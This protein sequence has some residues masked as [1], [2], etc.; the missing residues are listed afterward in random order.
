MN[1]PRNGQKGFTVL[2]L[3][4]TLV[5]SALLL[6]IAIPGFQN[7]IHS[8]MLSAGANT[9]SASLNLARA[10]AVMSRRNVRMCPS[11]NGTS[12]VNDGSW[13]GGWILF[14][15]DNGNGLP[16]T[17]ELLQARGAWDSRISL[18]TPA[19]FT[20]YI[21]FSPTGI[22]LGNAGSS[23]QFTLCSDGYDKYSRLVG[24]SATGRVTTEKQANLCV[25]GS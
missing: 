12:C 6:V 20:Q 22:V 24:I 25:E 11:T 19:A 14:Q 18:T 17:S 2:E 8:S 10:R 7:L 1:T 5:I 23:G 15:D 21:Q 16:S 4:I 9:F 13:T 3:M